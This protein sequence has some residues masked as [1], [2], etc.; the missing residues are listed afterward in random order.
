MIRKLLLTVIVVAVMGSLA[1]SYAILRNNGK[2]A[3]TNREPVQ[4]PEQTVTIIEGWT[5][6]DIAAML[7]KK[8]IMAATDFYAA[9]AQAD[10]SAYPV[11]KSL[12]ATADLE[13]FLFPDTYR[14]PVATS[15]ADKT[16][17]AA[18]I[19]KLLSNFSLKFTPEMERTAAAR[20]YSVF[21]IITL[22]SIIEKETGRN[23]VTAEQK[24]ELEKERRIVAGIFYNRLKAGHALQSDA[25]VNFTTKKNTP[26][27]S[28][29]DLETGS[30]YNTYK[31]PGLPPGPISNPSISSIQAALNPENTNYFYFLHKQP[32]GEPVYSV[33]H[34][35]HVANKFKYLK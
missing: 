31:Y 12:P 7:E 27:P 28:L 10:R 29:R 22:A 13:G 20:G 30:M 21:E 35:E 25:T 32:S 15:S 23:A 3:L 2:K 17:D 1:G 24:A 18:L 11:L 5:R 33:T 34:D 8:G 26:T 16:V 9:E 4:A 19:K 6:Q 14:L